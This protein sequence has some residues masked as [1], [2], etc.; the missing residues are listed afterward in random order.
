MARHKTVLDPIHVTIRI[1]GKLYR[2]IQEIA[3]I[4]SICRRR[5]HTVAE[6]IRD[7]LDFVYRDNEKMRECFRRCRTVGKKS[8]ESKTFKE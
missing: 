3:A 1:D 6:L 2:T 4:E 5:K 8:L 7:A